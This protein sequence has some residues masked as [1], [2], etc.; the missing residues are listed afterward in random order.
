[1]GDKHT[2][3]NEG[4]EE[5]MH[6]IDIGKKKHQH[7][8]IMI[9]SLKFLCFWYIGSMIQCIWRLGQGGVGNYFC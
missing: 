1:M 6:N 8:I 3:I 9:F 7:L 5:G 4:G 2:L